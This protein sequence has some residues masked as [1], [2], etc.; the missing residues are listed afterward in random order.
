MC[1]QLKSPFWSLTICE[2]MCLNWWSI[3]IWRFLTGFKWQNWLPEVHEPLPKPLNTTEMYFCLDLKRDSSKRSK[4]IGITQNNGVSNEIVLIEESIYEILHIEKYLRLSHNSFEYIRF[5]LD[6]ND[7][8]HFVWWANKRYSSLWNWKVTSLSLK[9]VWIRGLHFQWYMMNAIEHIQIISDKKKSNKAF[10]VLSVR[11]RVQ[12]KMHKNSLKNFK[13]FILR[14]VA[15]WASFCVERYVI[16]SLFTFNLSLMFDRFFLNQT[17]RTEILENIN[18]KTKVAENSQ[19]QQKSSFHW[20]QFHKL[21]TF[22][23][24]HP[25][26]NV[27]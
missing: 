26:C 10:D 4:S 11:E 16:Q 20:K 19:K 8:F 15:L 21:R 25:N 2:W 13:E 14:F 5:C 6:G 7:S 23:I 3:C 1:A 18:F 12:V 9:I 27:N 22:L 24:Q 17:L